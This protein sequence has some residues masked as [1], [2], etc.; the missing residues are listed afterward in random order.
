MPL[1]YIDRLCAG[2]LGRITR[3]GFNH[4][5]LLK[6]WKFAVAMDSHLPTYDLGRINKQGTV[7]E[8]IFSLTAERA[9]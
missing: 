6:S 9:L 1:L 3:V 2:G 8:F 4:S 7:T 5:C